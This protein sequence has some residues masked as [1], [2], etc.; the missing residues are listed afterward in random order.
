M[1]KMRAKGRAI[2]SGLGLP[3]R[4]VFKHLPWILLDPG[5]GGIINGEYQTKGKRSPVWEDGR[6]L[7]EGEFNRRVVA[8]VIN[9]LHTAGYP[10]YDIVNSHEDK[11]LRERS[12]TASEFYHN[13]TNDC[14][15]ISV[16][17]NAGEGTGFEIFTSP[18]ET[19]ADPMADIMLAAFT[20][21]FPELRMRSD[22]SDGDNDK[23]AKFHMIVNTPMPAMLIEC[24]FM[25]TYTPDCE[26]MLSDKGIT[27]FAKAIYY[28]IHA[29]YKNIENGKI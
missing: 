9:L 16:H 7:F 12:K 27:R 17:A 5:H 24:A 8:E 2:N 14:I 28:G 3:H 10:Y 21:E 1:T 20:A 4:K 19:S 26:L 22:D 6:Q 23:E 11:P 25:D 15:L 13:E 18:G 29:I